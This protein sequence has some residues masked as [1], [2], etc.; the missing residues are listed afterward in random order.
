MIEVPL[1]YEDDL[2]A[3]MMAG[4]R[5]GYARGRG[6]TG[7]G[8]TS[9]AADIMGARGE[10]AVWRLR[11]KPLPGEAEWTWEADKARLGD[12]D[13][14][15]VKTRAARNADLG[16]NSR[17][18]GAQILVLAHKAPIMAIAG[19]ATADEVRKLGTPVNNGT[20]DVRW[21][22]P[23]RALRPLEAA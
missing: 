21:Y 20:G 6:F 12:V 17:E 19:W 13:G 11:G 3:H 15:G 14:V 8:R 16:V 5:R 7:S 10:V 18:R 4:F 22:L 1:S 23:Q 2:Y 9:L